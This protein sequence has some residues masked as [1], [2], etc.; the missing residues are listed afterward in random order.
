M[1]NPLMRDTVA[2]PVDVKDSYVG[3]SSEEVDDNEDAD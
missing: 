2:M 1:D 3:E